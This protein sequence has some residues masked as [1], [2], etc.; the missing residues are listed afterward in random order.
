MSV[1]R[2]SAQ[3]SEGHGFKTRWGN[4]FF[5]IFCIYVSN[6]SSKI[7]NYVLCLFPYEWHWVFELFLSKKAKVPGEHRKGFVKNAFIRVPTMP[8]NKNVREKTSQKK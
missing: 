1:R 4:G 8:L 6:I 7:S 2:A 5:T 3:C